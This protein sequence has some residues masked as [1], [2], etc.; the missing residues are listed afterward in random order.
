MII[1]CSQC[2]KNFEIDSNL[3][4]DEGRLLQCSACH[5]KWFYKK[6]IAEKIVVT[7]EIEETQAHHKDKSETIIKKI[8]NINILKETDSSKTIKRKHS[9]SYA[10]NNKLNSLN[11]IL[12]LII[13]IVAL[14][15]IL[16][17]FKNPISLIIPDIKFI[18]GSLYETLK[19]ITLF[20]QDLFK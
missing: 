15:I 3:I 1:S 17:T 9:Y 6:K 16:D 11:L 18:L 4:P 10:K 19:D 2:H 5:H 13:S 20:I 14:I 12:V 7:S 8:N